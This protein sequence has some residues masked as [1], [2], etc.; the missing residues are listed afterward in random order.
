MEK[1]KEEVCCMGEEGSL[2]WVHCV[3]RH[4]HSVSV[5]PTQYSG[6]LT[7]HGTLATAATCTERLCHNHITNTYL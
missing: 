2:G 5:A 1:H 6:F 7:E 3:E 4:M